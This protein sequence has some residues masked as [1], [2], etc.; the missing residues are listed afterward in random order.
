MVRHRV[1]QRA[2]ALAHQSGDIP[3]GGLQG[4]QQA[5][6]QHGDKDHDGAYAADG[7]AQGEIQQSADGAAALARGRRLHVFLEGS[8]R[9]RQ[10]AQAE[11]SQD[12][13]DEADEPGRAL[14]VF[15]R[16]GGDAENQQ[17]YGQSDGHAAA[18]HTQHAH[19]EAAHQT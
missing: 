16:Y 12:K 8:Q 5:D 15:I 14:A 11:Q 17:R 4:Q 6:Q 13:Q 7:L 19:D 3:G 10:M 18:E 1:V 9:H 2:G